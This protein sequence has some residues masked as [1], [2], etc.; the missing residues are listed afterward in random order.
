MGGV[1]QAE[2]GGS[3]HGPGAAGTAAEGPANTDKGF[4]R[5]VNG[6]AGSGSSGAQGIAAVIDL[7]GGAPWTTGFFIFSLSLED[8]GP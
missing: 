6:P 2:L 4:I 3:A 5:A 8:P 1:L 7:K